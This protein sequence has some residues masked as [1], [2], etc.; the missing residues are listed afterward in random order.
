[1]ILFWDRLPAH[2]PEEMQEFLE[3]QKKW[4]SAEHFP[5]YVPE[6]NPLEYFFSAGKQR[7][8]ANLYADTLSEIDKA[9]RRHKNRVRRH[10]DL[11]TSFLKTSTLF[12]K[13]FAR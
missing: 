7:D 11:L 10:P 2:R 9:I 6:L 3:N 5:P 1:L 12:D 8:L 13:E 4:L